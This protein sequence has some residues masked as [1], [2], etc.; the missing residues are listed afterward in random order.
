MSEQELHHGVT[1]KNGSFILTSEENETVHLL[2][3]DESS[4]YVTRRKD[5]RWR[6]E[7]DGVNVIDYGTDF[8]DHSK[9]D[10]IEI[11]PPSTGIWRVLLERVK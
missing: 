4:V 8:F 3:D 9:D 5:E 6:I 1:I 2:N 10:P 7:A 11:V